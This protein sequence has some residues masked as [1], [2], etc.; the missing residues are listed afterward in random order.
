MPMTMA[1]MTSLIATMAA[2]NVALSRMP[3]TR[4]TVRMNVMRTAGRSKYEP[5][6]TMP[7]VLQSPP[8]L[9][10]KLNGAVETAGGT[11]K[12]NSGV[13]SWKCADQPCATV[14]E[15]T[16]YSRTRSQPMIQ[17]NSSPSVAYA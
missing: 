4:T 1:T 6:E 10:H 16:A 2:L 17:A 11:L 12:P 15:P 3:F 14:A 9:M 13:N 7:V 5:V 8:R